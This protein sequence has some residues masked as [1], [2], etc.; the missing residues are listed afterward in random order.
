VLDIAGERLISFSRIFSLGQSAEDRAAG[1][2][3]ALPREA[4]ADDRGEPFVGRVAELQRLDD[5]LRQAVAGAGSVVLISGDAGIGKTSLVRE[6]LRRARQRDASWTFSRSRCVAQYGPGEAYLPFLDAL[7]GLLKSSARERTVYLL[8]S[9]APTWALQLPGAGLPQDQ[10]QHETLGATKQRMLREFGDIFEYASVESPMVGFIEDMQWADPSSVDLLR[11]MSNRVSRLR[12]LVVV[13][14]RPAALEVVNPPLR[15]LAVEMRVQKSCH[16]IELGPLAREEIGAYLDARFAPHDLPAELLA[17][18]ADRT[19]GHPLFMTSLVQFLADQHHIERAADGRVRLT[20]P[21]AASD[22]AVPEDI[23]AL[24]LART[25]A[26]SAED[27][28]ALQYASVIGREFL[29]TPLAR[30]LEADEMAFEERLS[31]LSATQRLIEPLGEE[32]LPDG[33]LAVRYRF[34]NALYQEVLYE[35]IVSKRRVDLHR[36]LA[37]VLL[38]CYGAGAAQHAAQLALHF[39]RGREFRSAVAHLAQAGDNAAELYANREAV[40]HYDHALKLLDKLAQGEQREWGARLHGKRAA[41]ELAMSRFDEAIHGYTLMLE[42]SKAQGGAAE[43]ECAALSGLCNALLFAHRMEEMAV[44]T[45]EALRAAERSGSEPLRVE[46]ML[47]VAELLLESGELEECRP[48]LD[49]ALTTARRLG[50]KRSLLTALSAR[51]IMHYLQSEYR[52]AEERLAEGLSLASELRDVFRWL[53]CMRILGLTRMCLGRMSEALANFRQ[54]IELATRNGDRF[55]LPTL[56][57]HVGWG[58]RELQDFVHAIEHDQEG[59]RIAQEARNGSA[60]AQALLNLGIDCMLCG[61]CERALRLFEQAREAARHNYF[62]GWFFEIRL[63][64]ALAERALLVGDPELAAGHAARLLALAGRS[65]AGTYLA[66]GHRLLAELALRRS[67]WG[68][69]QASLAAAVDALGAHPAPLE[70]W[71]TYATLGRLHVARG[72]AAEGRLHY[73][74]AGVIVRGIAANV[75]DEALRETFLAAPA[76]GEVL[77]GEQ[78]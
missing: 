24:I 53:L 7:G 4:R 36:R 10:L 34:L 3:G 32:E 38:K 49:H 41:V 71:K 66:T 60:E 2:S 16:E 33:S 65:G 15:N 40:E 26:L 48:L 44:R 63:E 46:A 11:H 1:R 19:E 67:D 27:R 64:A 56:A 21:L 72:E 69:A 18:I 77:R 12:V 45:E 6:F 25:A 42:L 29:S 5:L 75:A 20:H 59:L 52:S 17:A 30:M 23:R 28:G 13:T 35:D 57:T 54:G 61:H 39:E 22:F 68:L 55:W 9:Y 14:Y 58:H 76:V 51:G 50:H 62:V 37:E 43:R 70:A 47:L 8:R 73:R 78:A 74:K 31:R